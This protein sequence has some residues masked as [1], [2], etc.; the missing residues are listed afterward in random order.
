M[1]HEPS[2]STELGNLSHLDSIGSCGDRQAAGQ[3]IVNLV[4][5]VNILWI[6]TGLIKSNI[7]KLI[8]CLNIGSIGGLL[9]IL[10]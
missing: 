2:Q 1:R 4:L 10:Q 9:R 6:G 3:I 7:L 5:L 8:D